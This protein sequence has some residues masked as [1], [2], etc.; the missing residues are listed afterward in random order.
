MVHWHKVSGAYAGR[1]LPSHHADYAEYAL[2]ADLCRERDA[3]FQ[4]TPDPRNWK[5]F[6]YLL[7]LSMGMF[8]RP[9]G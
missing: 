9:C 4:A 8:G 5:T 1:A 7:R 2:L 3:V 6:L